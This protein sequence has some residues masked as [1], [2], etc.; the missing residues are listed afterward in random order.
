MIKQHFRVDSSTYQLYCVISNTNPALKLNYSLYPLFISY[1]NH[2]NITELSQEENVVRFSVSFNMNSHH[3]NVLYMLKENRFTLFGKYLKSKEITQMSNVVFKLTISKLQGLSS[4]MLID[5]QSC[6]YGGIAL[7][8]YIHDDYNIMIDNYAHAE[9]NILHQCTHHNIKDFPIYL[10]DYKFLLLFITYKGYTEDIVELEGQIAVEPDHYLIPNS[11]LDFNNKVYANVGMTYMKR[12]SY[13]SHNTTGE[14]SIITWERSDL[15]LSFLLQPYHFN[16]HDVH[17][18]YIMFKFTS[19]NWKDRILQRVSV[20]VIL[21]F[22]LQSRDAEKCVY[23]YV[24]SAKSSDVIDSFE[25]IVEPSS[26]E[27]TGKLI[28]NV[29]SIRIYQ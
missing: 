9:L 7:Y 10:M 14:V 16:K 22:V 24:K 18:Y 4:S 15:T 20:T 29:D 1:D 2:A 28:S 11:Y 5:G 21:A 3:S 19:Y 8:Q 23:C 25:G 12:L 17:D 26:G 13:R 27:E 6:L